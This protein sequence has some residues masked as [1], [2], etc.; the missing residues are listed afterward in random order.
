VGAPEGEPRPADQPRLLEEI[1]PHPLGR[2]PARG[3]AFGWNGLSGDQLVF[4]A[5]F[6]GGSLD[7]YIAE[8][9]AASVRQTG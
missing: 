8:L 3:A 1:A 5:S 4:N 6:D 2:V 9:E 7:V